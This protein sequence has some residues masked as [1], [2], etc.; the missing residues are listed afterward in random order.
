[1]IDST[2]SARGDTCISAGPAAQHALDM[3]LAAWNRA[4]R[5]WDPDAFEDVYTADAV[6]FGG[7]PGH[8]VGRAGLRAYWESYVGVIASAEL[9]LQDYEL[10][11]LTPDLVLAQ[12]YGCFDLVLTDGRRTRSLLRATLTLVRRGDG[13][14]ALQHHFSTT[15]ET[16]PIGRET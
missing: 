5:N 1:M 13:W 3:V 12:G 9:K 16:P 4:G 2:T 8:S 10:L 14:K 15:P 6:F 11:Q 7:R